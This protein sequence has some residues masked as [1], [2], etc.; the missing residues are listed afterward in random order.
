VRRVPF[1]VNVSSKS[2]LYAATSK[3]AIRI[4]GNEGRQSYAAFACKMEREFVVCLTDLNLRHF[5]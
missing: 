2:S 3:F 1:K 5:D 4:D